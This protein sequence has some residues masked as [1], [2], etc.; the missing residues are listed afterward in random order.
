MARYIHG[1]TLRCCGR[2]KHA[3]PP[4]RSRERAN[5]FS[6]VIVWPGRKLDE[7]LGNWRHK[8]H[9]FSYCL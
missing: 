3:A 6:P 8:S 1:L 2:I 5:C 9:G 4:G 7:G